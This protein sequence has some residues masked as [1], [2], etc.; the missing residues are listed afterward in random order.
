MR[1]RPA[2]VAGPV[3][4]AAAAFVAPP[5]AA[6]E[7]DDATR[8]LIDLDQR[9]HVMALEF[10]EA[11]PPGPDLA[12]RRVVDAQVLFNLRNYDEAATILLDVVD[13]WPSS[14]AHQDAL[15]LL[16]EALFQLR[17]FH[18]SRRYFEQATTRSTG[19]K[20]E[21]QALQRLVEI[22]LRTGDFSNIDDYLGK[23]E[24]IPVQ[25][26]EPSV[27]YVR[28]KY[29]YFRDRLD[30]AL[31]GF[32]SILPSSPYYFQARYFAATIMVKRGDLGGGAAGFDAILKIQAPN[33]AAKEIQDLAHMAIA[34]ILYE[35]GQFDAGI[36]AYQAIPRH[37]KYFA[38]ALY[39]VAWSYI[40]AKEFQKAY[41]ALDLLL[42]T[43][44]D[45]TAAPELKLLMGNLNL[46]LGNFYLASDAFTKTRDEFDPIHRQLQGVIARS[47]TDPNFFNDLVGRSLD[48]FD[49]SVFI[50]A[51]AAKWVRTEP[52]VSSMLGLVTDVVEMKR[53][54]KDTE[55]LVARL[56]RA[57]GSMGKVGLFQDLAAAR[58]RS[59]E[60]LN[61]IVHIRQKFG[62][63]VRG[64][65]QAVLTPAE[66]KDMD[67]IAAERN[68]LEVQLRN[69]PL[70][71]ND[72]SVREKK[73]KG[74]F[75][76]LDGKASELNVEIQGME[77]QLVAIE[78]Y[79]LNSRTDQKIRPEDLE[80]P[81]GDLRRTVNELRTAHDKVREEI[82][83]ARRDTQAGGAAAEAERN[84]TT[85]LAELLKEEQTLQA[86]VKSRLSGDSQSQVDR[87]MGVLTRADAIQMQLHTFDQRID[88]QAEARLHGIRSA[89]ATEKEQLASASQ[90]MG[91]LVTESQSLGGGLAQVMFTR[92][93]DRFYDLVVRSDVGIIDVSWGLKDQKT[94]AVS[95]L[96]NQQKLEL[97]ALDEDFRRV[98]EDDK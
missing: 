97:K 49:I 76:T 28:A 92:V 2:R 69:L 46:R 50:P 72:L 75:A 90:K 74:E 22:S 83:E 66:V 61:Q 71:Q 62:A 17:D 96:V 53:A 68:S 91:D 85:R 44:P 18:S 39:E 65:Q 55:V 98:L 33:E 81:V 16:G 87:I 3:L 51:A 70:T 41:R 19:S 52:D 11:P 21:Q 10:R 67:R 54:I 31:A 27:P 93:A 42:L 84:A 94:N 58:G 9:V 7:V 32:N 88:A 12:D 5:A 78:Q 89:L 37:S 34:R 24:R 95:K 64:L 82:A 25:Y 38:D 47:Q 43:Q 45:S 63:R 13:R 23:L 15:F 4:A 26:L 80:R 40:K 8:K 86:Q 29:Y 36:E 6:D 35:R 1:L 73:T 14:R 48:K 20:Q 56:E 57:V 77:A 79:Y 30:D 60:V 59:V